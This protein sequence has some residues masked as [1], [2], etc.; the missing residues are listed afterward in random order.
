MRAEANIRPAY[1][2]AIVTLDAHAAG[3]AARVAPRLQRDFPGLAVSVHAAAEWAENPASLAIARAAVDQADIVVAN[4]LFIE[5][6][7]QAILPNLRAARDRADA[8]VGVIADPAVVKLTKMGDLDMGKPATGVMAFLKKLRGNAQPSASSGQA[9]M[10][11]LRRLPKILRWIPGK[12]QDLRAWFLSMQYWLG[13]SDDNIEEMLRFLVS[14]Y[15]RVRD[16]NRVQAKAPVEY[17]EVG[18]YHPRLPGRITTR[19]DDLP[20]PAGATGTVGLLLLRSYILASD[21]AHYDAVIAALEAKGLAVVPAFAGGLDGRRGIEAYMRGGGVDAL[22]WRPGFSLVG[23]PAY[24]DSP[25]AVATLSALDVPY[26]AAHPIEFQTLN[27]WGAAEG[28]LG[29]VETT[30][31]VALPEID[32]ATN[33]T[34]FAG[35]LSETTCTGCHMACRAAPGSRAMAPCPERI[36]V[37]AEKVR[38]LVALRR[39]EVAA[40]RVA[41]VLYGFPPNA[42]AAG[43]AAYLSVFES[44]QATLQAMK[45]AGYT[46]DPPATVEDLRAAVLGGNAARHGQPANVAAIVPAEEMVRNSPPLKAIEAVWGPAPGRQQSDGR[47]VFVLGAQFGN[48]FVGLQPVFGYEGDPMRLLFEKGFAPTH[49]FVQFYLWLRNTF[50]ADALLH[51]G[52]HGA[53]EFMPGRQAGLG[54]RDWPDRLVGE[55]PNIYLYAANNPSEASLAKRRANAVTVTH[56][57]PPLA[58]AGLYKGLADLKDSLARW[59]A[60]PVEDPSRRELTALIAVQAEAVDMAGTPPEALW[61]RLIEA[62]GALIPDGLHVMGRPM[63]PDARA[64]MIRLMGVTGEAAARAEAHLADNPEISALM[65][66][67][68]GR[69]I[70]P[71]PGG[72]LI[73]SPD[74]LPTG[75]NI[76]AFDPFRMPTAFALEDGRRQADRLLATHPTLPRS[77]ALVLWG[78]DNIKSDGGPIAQ[79]LALMGARPRF[80]SFGRLCGADLIPLADL[81]RPRI[82]VVMTL[83]GIF[84][85]LLPLQTRMLAEAA[86]KAASAEDEPAHLNFIR[87]HA[88]AYAAQM[89]TD[90]ETAALRVFSNAE[91]AYGANVNHLVGASAFGAEDEL[92]DAYEARKSFAYGRSGKPV[93]QAG[94][95]QAALKDVDLAYQ[96][97]ESVELGVTTVDHYFDTLGGIARA[98]KRARG[99][100]ETPV[101]IGDQTRGTGKV[102]TLRDQIALETRSRS[103][104]PRFYEALLKHGAE[105]VR[106]I[107]A[108]VTNTMGWSATAQAVDPWVYQR[109]SETFVLDETMRRRLAALNPEASARMA[110]RLIEAS[111]RNYWAPDPATLAALREAADEIEDRLEGIAAE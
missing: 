45:A 20:R 13:G 18:L 47:G 55:M 12:A 14:R 87:A 36:G 91:G 31:L 42:G 16:W 23:G 22:V 84:R 109:I 71:V 70:A 43:T 106:Q 11:L 60:L 21:A 64:G 49:A 44:L 1:S 85:D 86:W 77:V 10:T 33:P 107:E 39:S 102:R 61:V 101:Y 65:R 28:G 97:L 99:G 34:V 88:L 111:E 110:G 89:G 25:A 24:N 100:A 59:R 29:P 9:Q 75:R 51:F 82:D 26:V 8:F 46:L 62:E 72:D 83:S 96:N 52:M 67:L 93:K 17:P 68:S 27:Q 76:H 6:H 90:L 58:A 50:R 57:T 54:A 40:R 37:L 63:D 35:R 98:V 74:I 15:S 2:V 38:R 69:Y 92:A 78:S 41:V 5:E 73:R 104:N 30:M 94:L 53:L 80:D 19:A 81:G 66:A 4:L 56:L 103:L 108:Q 48:V 7:I 79:A 105:G 32:G 95:L 3:P